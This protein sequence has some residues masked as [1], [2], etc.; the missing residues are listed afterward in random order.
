MADKTDRR[1]K[2][3]SDYIDRDLSW[4]YFNRRILQEATKEN[5]PLLE[6]L[7]FLGIYSNNLD[8]FFRV[9]M[10]T[11]SRIA[12][13]EDKSLRKESE[14]ARKLIKRINRLN[15]VYAKEYEEALAGVRSRLRDEHIF[16]LNE[17]E[18]DEEQQRYVR[19]FFRQR[20]SGFVSPVWITAARQLTEETDD[21]IY[22][23]VKMN[24]E[25][26]KAGDY[27]LIEL[28]VQVSGRFVRLPDR[29]G[30]K[31]LMYL[32]DVIRYCLPFIFGGLGYTHF[33][34][35]AFKFT[36]DAEMEIGNDLRTGVLQKISKGVKSRRK[37]D[38][39]RVIYDQDMPAALHKRVMNLLN[40]DKLDTVQAGGRYHNH[41]D[42]MAFP[43]CGRDDLKY[44]VWKPLVRPETNSSRDSVLRMVQEGD[45]FIHVPY[46][47]FDYYIRLLQEAAIHKEVKSIKT[48]LYRLAKDSKVVKALICAARNGKKVTVVIELLARFDEASNINWSKKM[49]DAGVNVI[50]GVENLK[51]HSKITH[52]GMRNGSD[53]ACVSTGNFHEGNARVYTDYMLMTA[54]KNI[55]KDV[56]AVFTF[57]EKPYMPVTFK[58]LLVSPNEMKKKFVRLINN[59]IR[60]RQQG[61]PAYIKVKINHITEPEMVRKLYEASE[62]GVRVDLLV[63]GN[64]SLVTG[65]PGKSDNISICG[66]I[67]RYLEHSRIFIFANGGEKKCFIGSADWMPRNLDNRIEVVTPV[68]DAKI[69]E[70]LEKVIDYGLRD[71]MQGRIVDGTGENRPWTT[72]DGEAFRSQ[73]QLYLH[74]REQLAGET[75]ASE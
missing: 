74:Y 7:G 22:L 2:A 68:Y 71:T 32:D 47:S 29:D 10:A 75:Q 57:I 50:F 61:K 31:Y 54:A 69:K 55:V 43:D 38:A 45:R 48:T 56:N 62:N 39:L 65:I 73:E 33:E 67:D 63:R 17:N 1:K 37:G 34:A 59:E 27:A 9:R 30:N 66:I 24:T 41:K 3:H 51:V 28:P 11:L 18:L 36:K 46:H 16:L 23:A 13:C 21:S 6:R 42:L 25:G 19:R 35:Y 26:R 4:M 44:P 8:E 20:L 15:A 64:C 60:N 40:L 52:I 12:E 49:Q 14:H 5:V 53:I 72:E 70:D 58:E